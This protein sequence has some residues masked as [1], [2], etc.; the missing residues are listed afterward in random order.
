MWKSQC[1]KAQ[2]DCKLVVWINPIQDRP[3]RGCPRIGEETKSPPPPPPPPLPPLPKISHTY[4]TMI[5]LC[6]Y[7]LP[8]EDPKKLWMAGYTSWVLLTSG[9]FNWKSAKF[10]IS[11]NS[12][13]GC[14]LIHNFLTSFESLKINSINTVTFLMVSAKMATLDP[15][16][17]YYFEIKIMTS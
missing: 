13:I 11:R 2:N 1:W 10:A 9:F 3:S 7:T 4:P 12:D 5:K 8:K 17:I 16:K 15:L 6:S 14:I